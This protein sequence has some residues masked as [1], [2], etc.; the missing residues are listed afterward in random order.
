[1][2]NLFEEAI[3]R[4]RGI[5]LKRKRKITKLIKTHAIPLINEYFNNEHSL[6]VQGTSTIS[7]KKELEICEILSDYAQMIDRL[8]EERDNIYNQEWVKLVMDFY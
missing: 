6:A 5:K 7:T 8:F 4:D 2:S 3:F 1:M